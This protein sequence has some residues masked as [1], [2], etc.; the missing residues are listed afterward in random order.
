MTA[1]EARRASLLGK[2][3]AEHGVKLTYLPF[4]IEVVA[5]K[6]RRFPLLNASVEGNNIRLHGKVNIGIAVALE[7]GLI[8]PVIRDADA[9]GLPELAKAVVDLAGRGCS[10]RRA[11]RLV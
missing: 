5:A 11:R 4:I 7:D 1:I 6:L 9:K 8:V 2:F 10:S 3:D